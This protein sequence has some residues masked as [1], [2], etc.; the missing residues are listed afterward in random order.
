MCLAQNFPVYFS[1]QHNR[2]CWRLNSILSEFDINALMSATV[3]GSCYSAAHSPALAA[4]LRFV[5]RCAFTLFYV[6]SLLNVI[7]FLLDSTFVILL[8][9]YFFVIAFNSWLQF[10]CSY[11]YFVVF[12][13]SI[14]YRIVSTNTSTS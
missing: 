1:T 6:D 2:E 7:Q 8:F 4:N 10:R 12:V 3:N 13:F 9:I 11:F 5:L 14:D